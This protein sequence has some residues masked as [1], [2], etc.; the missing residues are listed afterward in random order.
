MY[1]GVL[2][3]TFLKVVLSKEFFKP[4]ARIVLAL[5]ALGLAV[6]AYLTFLE[7]FVIKA[8]CMWCLSSAAIVTL[9]LITSAI[10]NRRLK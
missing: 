1:L 10:E 4:I 3:A 5:S 7:A 2:V 8:Y 9:L 6:S